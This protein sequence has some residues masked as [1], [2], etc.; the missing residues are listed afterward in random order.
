MYYVIY[1]TVFSFNWEQ[2]IYTLLYG[3]KIWRV[4]RNKNRLKNIVAIIP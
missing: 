4:I 1:V 3:Y 2:N